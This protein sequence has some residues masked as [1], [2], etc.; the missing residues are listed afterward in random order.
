MEIPTKDGSLLNLLLH[1]LK[2]YLKSQPISSPQA[3]HSEVV[4]DK[5]WNL[6]FFLP[7]KEACLIQKL[8]T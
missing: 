7:Q 8:R 3:N 2:Q 5:R 6:S 4:Q 1:V